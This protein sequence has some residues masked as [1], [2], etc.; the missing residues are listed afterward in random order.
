[1]S[2]RVAGSIATSA[3]RTNEVGMAVASANV[4]NAGTEGY[5][6]KTAKPTTSDTAVGFTGV[7][8]AGIGST[9]DRYLMTSL[10]SAQS[11]L[12]LSRTVSDYLDRFQER[13]GATTSASSL[14]SVID[15]LGET[16][17]TLATS[18]ESG[19]AKA[20]A[21]DD[22]TAVAETLRS[23]AKAVQELRGE[24]DHAIAD[25]VTRINGTLD[26][27]KDLNDRIQTGKALGQDTGDL[28]D[29]RNTALK[30]LAG[31]IDIRYQTDANGMVR[32][33]TSSGTS[34]LDSAVHRLS[35]TPANTV[36][37]GTSFNPITI[38]GKDVTG[39]V[40]SGTLGGLIQVRDTDL[41][42]Q[43][44]RLDELALTLKDTLNVLHNQGTAVPPPNALT[45]SAG[46]AGSDAL[47]GNGTLRVAVTAADGTAVEVLDL[48]LSAYATVQDAVDAI[49]A[50]G[51][52]SAHLDAQGRLV[53]QA[54]DAA[55]GVALGGD[56]TAG[57]DGKG[58][59]ARFG[60]NDLLTG[61]GAADLRVSDA[62]ARDSGR[63]ATGAL[64]T[65][66]TLAAGGSALS[67]GEGSVAQA[68]KTAFSGAQSFDTAGGLSGRTGTFSQYAGAIIQGAATA[69]SRAATAYEDQDSYASGLES[70][71][72]SQSGVNV[73]EETAA[74]S[75]LQSAYQAAA[76]VMKAVQEMFDTA[77][78]L[79][80]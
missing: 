70:T 19:S 63:L 24:A 51:S 69:A 31:D 48:D 58:F 62:I 68:L 21:V 20:A 57:A 36:G 35:Y 47:N 34:L 30:S 5:T 76:A 18:P 8:V 38:D 27:L 45:G 74:I 1:M 29:Q 41:P 44:A 65:S 71:M 32:V 64:S 61:T 40:S 22:L 23:T 75:N 73:N 72:A 67:A 26:T 60:L 54:D 49:D 55:N 39:S 78:N 77:L 2:L 4:A 80:R 66:A 6:R 53:I 59:S 10:V 50:M 33:S 13:L 42:A 3:L 7:E 46:V 28:E 43:Q 17:A 16:L 37:A 25:T 11:G 9:V 15:T 56:G 79:V 52:L 14:G 12:G